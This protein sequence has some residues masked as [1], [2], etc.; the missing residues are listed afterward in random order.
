MAFPQKNS[1]DTNTD[2]LT[3][4]AIIKALGEFDLDPCCPPVMPWRTARE[5]ISSKADSI[6]YVR[7]CS[8]DTL[9][10]GRQDVVGA[11]ESF[12]DRQFAVY[13][14]NVLVVDDQQ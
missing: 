4:P 12:S 14:L 1:P 13:L 11:T 2:W 7:G 5:M 9:G 6:R 10:G 8:G 3:P